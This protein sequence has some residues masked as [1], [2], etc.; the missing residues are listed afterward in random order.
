MDRNLFNLLW[1]ERSYLHRFHRSG[2][3]KPRR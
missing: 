1:I 2:E 3:I